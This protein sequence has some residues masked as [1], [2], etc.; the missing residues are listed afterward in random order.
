MPIIKLP[1]RQW[2]IIKNILKQ[3]ISKN[4][5]R[6]FSWKEMPMQKYKGY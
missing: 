3:Q 2:R 1:E 4:L 6:R 5:K